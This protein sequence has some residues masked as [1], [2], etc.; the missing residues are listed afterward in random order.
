M[1]PMTWEQY[2]AEPAEVVDAAL[3]FER[4][5]AEVEAAMHRRAR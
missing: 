3:A 1:I 5:D 2:R 4:M